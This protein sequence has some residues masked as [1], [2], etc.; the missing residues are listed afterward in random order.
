MIEAYDLEILT[1]ACD[2]GS[3]RL[4]AKAALVDD[5]APVLPYL[6]ATLPG[7]NYLPEARALIWEDESHLVAFHA[8]EI[9]VAEVTGREDAEQVMDYYVRLVNETWDRR[10]E[11][12]PSVATLPRPTPM[13]VY[14]K[15]PGTNCKEC[16]LPGCWQFALKLV[17]GEARLGDCPALAEP[18]FAPQL[19]DLRSHGV[20]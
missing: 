6:N 5:I 19:A 15:L 13:E 2:P 9:A 18:E 12:V 20:A 7:A 17:A 10:D 11:I 16:H 3:P 4:V 14:R 1:P 8:R